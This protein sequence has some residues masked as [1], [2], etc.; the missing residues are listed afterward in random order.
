MCFCVKLTRGQFYWLVVCQLD[1]GWSDHREKSLSWGIA[2]MRS[3]WK[4]F[5]QLVMGGGGSLWVGPSLDW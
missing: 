5:S 1:T 2:S 4:A 3:S